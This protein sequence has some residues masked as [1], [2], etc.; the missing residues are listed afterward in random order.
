MSFIIDPY[1]FNTCPAEALA[2]IT[3]AGITDATQRQAICTLVRDLQSYGIW[4]KMKAIYPMVGG[5]STT[6]KYNLKDPRDLDAAY[7]LV[8]SGG[9]TF[10]NTGALPNGVNAA[11]NTFLTQVT[12]GAYNNTHLSYYSRSNVL[13]TNLRV[14]M[15]AGVGSD[16]ISLY[17]GLFFSGVRVYGGNCGSKGANI[18]NPTN[19]LGLGIN[20]ATSSTLQ[21]IYRNGIEIANSTATQ[22]ATPSSLVNIYLGA[23]GALSGPT[24]FSNRECAF[25]SIGDGLTD[26][27]AANLY[28]AVQ[29]YQTTLGR[30]V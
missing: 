25:A 3:A 26:A 21:K 27:D 11:A 6:C 16:F 12:S 18:T 15:G 28:T 19:T 20:N 22:T 5:T 30:Q 9:W 8:F 7:R 17:L 29:F 24:A 4:N 13:D 23:Q 2:F 14:E 1:R 10:S